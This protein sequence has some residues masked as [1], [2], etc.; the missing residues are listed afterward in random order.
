MG[1]VVMEEVKCS[2]CGEWHDELPMSFGTDAPY[3]YDAIAPEERERRAELY[4]DQ[5]IVD[6]EHLF[7]PRLP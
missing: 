5:C 1:Y 4:S 7:R 3:W 6:D 2:A